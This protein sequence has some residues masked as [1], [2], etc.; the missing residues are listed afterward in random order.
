MFDVY[1]K[2][3]QLNK[4][5]KYSL[6]K[7]RQKK[8]RKKETILLASFFPHLVRW[9]CPFFVWVTLSMFRCHF[10]AVI[11]QQNPETWRLFFYLSPFF[12]LFH[13]F[14]EIYSLCTYIRA[15]LLQMPR[16][17]DHQM[18][19]CI[20]TSQQVQGEQTLTHLFPDLGVVLFEN[21]A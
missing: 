12:N 2:A 7:N 13:S 11:N 19:I 18:V 14:L 9:F 16:N 3:L 17:G 21:S 10:W 1:K 8:E 4:L 5:V 15:D 6:I 20:L